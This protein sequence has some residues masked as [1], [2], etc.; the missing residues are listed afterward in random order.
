MTKAQWDASIEAQGTLTGFMSAI[1]CEQAKND[2]DAALAT[3]L[4]TGGVVT[5]ATFA[6]RLEIESLVTLYNVVGAGLLSVAA[7]TQ[8]I[9]RG[10]NYYTLSGAP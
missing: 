3:L 9:A 4:T 2:G 1:H 6:S 7:R 5:A 10:D 8:L